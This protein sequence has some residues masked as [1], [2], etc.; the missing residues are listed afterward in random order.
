MRRLFQLLMV[1]MLCLFSLCAY[2]SGDADCIYV[3]YEGT[4]FKC[5]NL[6]NVYAGVLKGNFTDD[7][8]V[9][10]KEF[11]GNYL[12]LKVAVLN[13]RVEP[14]MNDRSGFTLFDKVKGARF[15]VDSN[16]HSALYINNNNNAVYTKLNPGINRIYTL[17]FEIP[18]NF[19][20]DNHVLVVCPDV[21]RMNEAFVVPLHPHKK[22]V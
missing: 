4:D 6:Q 16:I 3:N 11:K 9:G 21:N 5:Y 12:I 17:V 1:L 13:K 7:L 18:A 14:I 19:V 8:K 15:E 2:A 20:A 10:G 22:K